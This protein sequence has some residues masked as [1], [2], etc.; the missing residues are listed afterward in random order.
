MFRKHR[1]CGR[2]ITRRT[3]EDSEGFLSPRLIDFLTF[4]IGNAWRGTRL[5]ELFFDCGGGLW[6]RWTSQA[7]SVP[8]IHTKIAADGQT[9]PSRPRDAVRDGG[10]P[11]SDPL[12][13]PF[14]RLFQ[15]T[16]EW[17]HFLLPLTTK[18]EPRLM[19]INL[20][21][22]TRGLRHGL[23]HCKHTHTFIYTVQLHPRQRHK[24]LNANLNEFSAEWVTA[25]RKMAKND[26]DPFVWAFIRLKVIT[27][28]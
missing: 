4:W 15:S 21:S 27:R 19:K 3:G 24:S 13:Q 7:P 28:K 6:L 16:A 9:I 22:P 14:T 2:F 12:R 23:F 5:P 11:S 20:G 17:K 18:I 25:Q 10:G 8:F 1:G 26:G